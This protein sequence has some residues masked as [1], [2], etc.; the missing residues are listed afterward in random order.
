[1]ALLFLTSSDMPDLLPYDQEVISKLKALKI[2]VDIIDWE[3]VKDTN[4]NSL[5]SYQA[6]LIRTI[7]NYYK[8]PETFVEFLDYC[9]KYALPLL[10]PVDIVR[11]NM[12]KRY[13]QDLQ[14]EGIELIP[15]EFVFNIHGQVFQKALRRGWKKMVLKPMISGGSY[16]TFVI[17]DQEENRFNKLMVEHFENRPFLLQEFIP[18]IEKGEISTLSFANGFDYSITKVPKE[19]DYRVQFNYG[20]VYHIS[21]VDTQ[22]Q[23]ISKKMKARF[24][25]RQLY[26]RVDGIWRDGRF[27]LME[28]EL[29]EPDLYL[30][31]HPE[32]REE[33]V[34]N[35][36]FIDK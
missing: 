12:D 20:G 26:Q 1:M 2:K 5:K 29:I 4:P 21:E 9:E 19:G 36:A 18:E 30:G 14:S 35:L 8:K 23:A 15:T 6:I 33:W 16:H 11:W 10:N 27:L 22:I 7:W 34:K 32:A 28:V 3:K 25:N 31:H 24:N 13:L 17:S